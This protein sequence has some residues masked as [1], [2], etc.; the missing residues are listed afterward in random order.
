MEAAPRLF[1]WLCRDDRVGFRQLGLNGLAFARRG[2][3][4]LPAQLEPL[5]STMAAAV[6]GTVS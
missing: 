3:R 1:R 6:D 2:F 5:F 4:K